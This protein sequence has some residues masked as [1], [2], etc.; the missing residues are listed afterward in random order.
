LKDK[1]SGVRLILS[2]Y[3]LFLIPSWIITGACLSSFA[4]YGWETFGACIW[5]KIFST[6]L[7][8]YI[9]KGLCKHRFYYYRNLGW[10]PARLWSFSLGMD[11]ALFITGI[12]LFK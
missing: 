10:S 6:A 11:Y 1:L 2:F 12:Y 4:Q 3:S 9:V 8:M 7:I 5:G